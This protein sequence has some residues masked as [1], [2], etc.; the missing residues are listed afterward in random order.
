MGSCHDGLTSAEDC[1][2]A[3]KASP[4]SL[5]FTAATKSALAV[6]PHWTHEI[7]RLAET[8]ASRGTY[9]EHNETSDSNSSW[10]TNPRCWHTQSIGQAARPY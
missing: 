8:P 5:I 10:H 1:V 7:P 6:K 3:N 9:K 4:A 2:Q